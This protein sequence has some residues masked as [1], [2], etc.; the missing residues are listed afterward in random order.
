[1]FNVM[2]VSA[3]VII[4]KRNWN[5]KITQPLQYKKN[6]IYID[7]CYQNNKFGKFSLDLAIFSLKNTET[8]E[9]RNKIE[10]DESECLSKMFGPN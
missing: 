10:I 4:N 9:F 3:E 6:L 1:M 5:K 8:A 2:I 7:Q